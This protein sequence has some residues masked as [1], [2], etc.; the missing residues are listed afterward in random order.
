M[1]RSSNKKLVEELLGKM[2]RE[3]VISP[4][5]LA[6]RREAH[7]QHCGECKHNSGVCQELKRLDALVAG[8]SRAAAWKPPVQ[9]PLSNLPVSWTDPECLRLQR[10]GD[11][12]TYD[13]CPH[14]EVYS[15]KKRA[16]YETPKGEVK[17]SN[18]GSSDR[19]A[20]DSE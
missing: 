13:E 8:A 20:K 6:L 4:A 15:I 2:G 9:Q 7:K 10:H 11:M 14:C 19:G 3:M 1:P 17:K 5:E 18:A 12:Q 16:E